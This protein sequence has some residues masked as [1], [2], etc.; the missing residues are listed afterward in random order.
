MIED[1]SDTSA[2]IP[3]RIFQ[4]W[5]SKDHLPS[6]WA[7]W[8]STL[9][10]KNPDFEFDF[11]DDDDNRRFIAENFAWF[12]PYYDA[13]PAEIYRA[14]M[15]RYFYLYMNGGFYIDLDTECLRSLAEFLSY[16][17]VV[18]GRMGTDLDFDH[19]IPNA[20]MASR[21]R[22]EFWLL[23]ISLA[24]DWSAHH[25][26]RPDLLTGP[27]LLRSAFSI[28]Q[29]NRWWGKFRHVRRCKRLLS[30]AQ[31]PR[32]G[33]SQ[34]FIL[35]PHEWFP[36]DWSNASDG[37]LRKQVLECQLLDDQQKKALFPRSSLVTYWAHSW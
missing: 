1:L 30:S 15:I 17:G 4:T 16:P 11:W 10:N 8:R 27:V 5:K 7:Y 22:E 34:V 2:G 33:T 24:M 25:E 23:V 13:Y 28:Y 26:A 14:D 32:S 9:I 35:P 12:L 20:I 3:S 36:I 18:L 19:S 37:A 6:K 31:Q 29:S 21:P